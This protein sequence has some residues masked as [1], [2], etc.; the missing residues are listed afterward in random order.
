MAGELHFLTIA[1]AA[2]LIKSRM[3]SPV[4]LT[5]ALLARVNALDG[6]IHAF[7]TLTPELALEQ[8]AQAEAEITAGR[9]RGPLHGIPIGIKDIYQT[10]GILTT[11]NSRVCR[12]FVPKS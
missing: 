3:L 7:I 9:Y 2:E 8:A 12:D 6:Q 10:A 11:G 1:E 4:E 5:R